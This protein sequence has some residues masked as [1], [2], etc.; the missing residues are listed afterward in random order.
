MT[1]PRSNRVS[2]ALI[3]GISA[4]VVTVTGAAAW[5][6]WNSSNNPPAP[7]DKSQPLNRP[8]P[9]PGTVS[10]KELN[11]NIY[12]LKDNGKNL[13]LVA[14]PIRVAN[15]KPNQVLEAAFKVLLEKQNKSSAIPKGTKILGTKVEKDT[16]RINL[17]NEFTSGGGS[18]SMT[19]RVGQVIYTATALNPKAKVYISVNGKQL[20]VLG[21]EGLELEQPMTREIFDKEYQL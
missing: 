21:G 18:A 14:Q 11:T 7:P 17:S 3:A 12:L 19:G 10:G 8:I 6:A 1:Q 15:G 16:V 13:V 5:F 20:D 9:Q 4:A 2:S